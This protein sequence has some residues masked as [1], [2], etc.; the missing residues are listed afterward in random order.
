MEK[1][2]LCKITLE[3]KEED[4]CHTCLTFLRWKYRK[5]QIS[6]TNCKEVPMR[7]VLFAFGVLALA[8]LIGTQ[9]V[10]AYE[11]NQTIS[12][13]DQHTFDQILEPVLK[14]YNLVKYIS[15]VLAALVFLFAGITYVTS[16]SDPKKRDTAKNMA[17]YVLIGLVLIWAAPLVVTFIVG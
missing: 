12:E 7:K 10:L 14:V 4:F 6:D 17:M 11:F 15:T 13:A 2:N 1:C 16:G 9:L 5:K 3:E 8:L